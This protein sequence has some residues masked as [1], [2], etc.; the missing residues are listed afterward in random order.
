M[1]FLNLDQNSK[2]N[3]IK[4]YFIFY[5]VGRI[6][7]GNVFVTVTIEVSWNYFPFWLVDT[8]IKYVGRI[9]RIVGGNRQV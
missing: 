9:G 7:A 3:Y 2:C 5:S 4:C 6:V 1:Y 8:D